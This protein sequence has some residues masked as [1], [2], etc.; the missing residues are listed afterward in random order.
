VYRA[1][2]K[3]QDK[4]GQLRIYQDLRKAVDNQSGKILLSLAVCTG[5]GAFLGYNN[6]QG[7]TLYIAWAKKEV[8]SWLVGAWI[9]AGLGMFH[10]MAKAYVKQRLDRLES[11][12]S[13]IPYRR[14]RS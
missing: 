14:F 5:I 4:V 7:D 6:T 10:G 13:R 11:E 2:R 8:P 12:S 9:G 3:V 1:V